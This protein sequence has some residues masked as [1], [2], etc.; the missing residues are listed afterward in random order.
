M[1]GVF[2]VCSVIYIYSLWFFATPDKAKTQKKR[3]CQLV[4]VL[5]TPA[6][7]RGIFC[8][9]LKNP[10]VKSASYRELI[11]TLILIIAVLIISYLLVPLTLQINF[12][13]YSWIPRRGPRKIMEYEYGLRTVQND[14]MERSLSMMT[15]DSCIWL[16]CIWLLYMLLIYDYHMLLSYMMMIGLIFVYDCHICLT[17]YG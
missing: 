8:T 3:P 11:S 6:F 16:P 1:L 9:D 12:Q 5:H 15:Y 2:C 7:G 17:I 14:N 13:P 4:L 10:T